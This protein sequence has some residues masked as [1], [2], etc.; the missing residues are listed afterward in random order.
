[1]VSI[2]SG[3]FILKHLI[4]RI[5]FSVIRALT[6]EAQQMVL[7][8]GVG[9]EYFERTPTISSTALFVDGLGQL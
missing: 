4:L 9:K 1:M 7:R 6:Q 3:A 2:Q 5:L 8:A